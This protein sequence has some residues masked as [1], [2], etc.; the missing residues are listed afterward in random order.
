M[1]GSLA[2]VCL[3]PNQFQC[4]HATKR[5]EI[6]EAIRREP[7]AYAAIDEWLP[8]VYRM[9]LKWATN[10]R[11]KFSRFHSMPHIT[12]SIRS[13]AIRHIC[14]FPPFSTNGTSDAVYNTMLR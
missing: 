11:T 2:D 3:H 6:E 5:Q 14:L 10:L 4:W 1:L 7:G 13:N 8:K 9:I 12:V